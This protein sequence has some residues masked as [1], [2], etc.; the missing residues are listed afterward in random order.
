MVFSSNIFLFA[1]LP[2]TLLF[3]FL[4]PKKLATKNVKNS[5]L[6]IASLLF[7]AWGEMHYLWLLLFSITA[8]YFFGILIHKKSRNFFI[9]IAIIFNLALLGYFKYSNFLIEN[10]NQLFSLQI[11]NKKISLPI[12]ISFFSSTFL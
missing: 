7:Y 1:F 8:N 4:S 3:Y 5:I 2:L 9:T 6:L 12:G 11:T 10:L